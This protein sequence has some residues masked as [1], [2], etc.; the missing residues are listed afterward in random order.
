MG[1]AAQEAIV[2]IEVLYGFTFRPVDLRECR[3][4]TC[5]QKFNQQSIARIIYGGGYL[6]WVFEAA[7]DPVVMSVWWNRLSRPQEQAQHTELASDLSDVRYA[8]LVDKA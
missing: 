4:Q 7:F 3:G 5:R 2:R 6:A 8:T 1:Q